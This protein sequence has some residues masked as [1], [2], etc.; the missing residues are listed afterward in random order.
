MSTASPDLEE[1]PIG[2]RERRFINKLTAVTAGGMFI[3]G[4]VLGG[5]GVAL[6]LIQDDLQPSPLV[7]GLIGASALIGVFIGAPLFGM[8][9]DRFGRKKLFALDMAL[10]LVAS[11]SQFFVDSAWLLFVV[12]LVMGIAVGADYAIGSALLAE[13]ARSKSRGFRMAFLEVGWYLGF[14]VSF[15]VAYAMAQIFDASWQL[16]LASSSIPAII[17]IVLRHGLPESPRWL[18]SRGREAEARTVLAHHLGSDYVMPDL[19]AEPESAKAGIR[20]LFGR[21]YGKRTAFASIFW[22][23]QVLPYFAI[24]TFAPVVLGAMGL[25]D[26]LRS[27]LSVNGIAF[28][29]SIVGMILIDRIGR[30]RL[31]IVPFWVTATALLILGL[32]HDAPIPIVITC[33]LVFAFFNAGSSVLQGV[34]PMEIF[35]TAV[36]STGVGIAAAGSRIGA[37]IGTFLLPLGLTSWGPN[38]IMLLA[39]AVLVIGAVTSHFWAPETAG[40]SL[41]NAS[42][43]DYT[44]DNF[45]A[46]PPAANKNHVNTTL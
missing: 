18:I 44:S 31:L 33:F 17:V 37:A 46:E 40:L 30:R 19:A 9:T 42:N 1:P 8:A 12:R 10:F 43:P 20:D 32:W 15:S 45:I 22:V 34:Y 35:P 14:L 21:R 4:Y 24:F 41:T 25:N 11:I 26:E 13:F 28:V 5:I 27:S 38:A 36:R 6:P 3:D 2:S 23:C 29:G 7:L 39:A 16:M